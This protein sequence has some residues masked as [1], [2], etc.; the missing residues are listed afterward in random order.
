MEYQPELGQMCFGQPWQQKECPE[1]V[2]SALRALQNTFEAVRDDINPFGNNG[3]R[4]DG[5]KFKAHAYSW[6]DDDQEFNF[7]WRDVRVSW[8]KYLG[9]GTTINRAMEDAEVTQM[10][11]ECMAELLSNV[12]VTGDGRLH[13]RR[14]CGLPGSAS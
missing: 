14:P 1:K 4:F 6:S 13:G 12:E 9:R 2:L 5:E 3:T 8:C 10:L 7:A 11:R